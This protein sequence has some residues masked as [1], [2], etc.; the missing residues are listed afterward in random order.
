MRFR[1]VPTTTAL[2]SLSLTAFLIG[3]DRGGHRAAGTG[4]N[5]STADQAMIVEYDVFPTEV[6]VLK[7]GESKD[8]KLSRKGNE[9]KDANLVVTSADP[10]VKVE[11][12]Q[13]KANGREATV[14]IK[15][16]ADA[17]AKDHAITI[18][19]GNTTKT[20]NVRV[21]SGAASTPT[22]TDIKK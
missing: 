21:E 1:F 16:D 14:T 4:A 22:N 2:L 10:K 8:V 11:G 3:C 18:R 17:P 15:A 13:F 7:Q 5:A 12:G 19:S 9:L 6:V 20:I